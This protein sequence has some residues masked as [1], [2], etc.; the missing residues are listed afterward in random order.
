MQKF[1][2]LIEI[3]LKFISEGPI[4]NRSALVQAMTWQQ[5]FPEPVIIQF[6]DAYIHMAHLV[7]GSKNNDKPY[8]KYLQISGYFVQASVCQPC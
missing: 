3:L 1:I 7:S 6:H 2:D 5:P 8:L 4:D